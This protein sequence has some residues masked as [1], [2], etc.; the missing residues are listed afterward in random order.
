MDIVAAYRVWIREILEEYHSYKPVNARPEIEEQI[1]LDYENDHYL[2]L[3]V[4]WHGEERTYGCSLHLDIKDGKIW[5][6]RDWIDV[7][8]GIAGELMAH[9]VPK[10]DIVL[11]FQAP[12]K[13]P[14]SGFA[15][16]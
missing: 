5:I 7:E 8:G 6:Q 3:Q 1:V 13:R 9:G 16:A 15:V 12:Y 4:G 14:Y 2:L 10:E 11:G